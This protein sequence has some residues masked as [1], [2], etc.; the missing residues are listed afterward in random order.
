MTDRPLTV[1]FLWEIKG[2]PHQTIHDFVRENTF[3]PEGSDELVGVRVLDPVLL[4]HG[5][6]RNA[7]DI[8]QG[9]LEKPRQDVKHVAMLG[10]CV[11]QFLEDVRAQVSDEARRKETL[12]N[13]IRALTALKHN[14]SGR[15][16]DA[17]HPGVM[18][19]QEL[20]PRRIQQMAFDRE[21]RTLLRQLIGMSQSRG[22]GI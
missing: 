18:H 11:P 6:I 17:Q 9:Q 19:W 3:Q 14:Y 4:L 13:Y 1:E 8:E 15:Q 10:L 21:I 7:V 20:I 5:K 16:F 12:G 2:V 22:I